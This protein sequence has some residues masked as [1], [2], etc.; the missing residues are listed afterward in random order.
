MTIYKNSGLVLSMQSAIAA[1]KTITLATNAAPGVFTSVGHGYLDGDIILVR[2]SG[3]IEVNER[4]FVV[5]NKAIDTF[6]LKNTATGAVGIDTT[7]FGVFSS[8]SAEKVTLA[9]SIPGVQEFSPSG[10]EIEFLDTTTVSDTRKKQMV[11]GISAM[12]YG[13][14]MMWDPSDTAQAAMQAAFETSST[15]SF[16]IKW[17]DGRYAMFF[18]SVGF[19]GA[20]GGGNQGITTTQAAISMNGNATYGIP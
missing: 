2:T 5:A 7:L 16:R 17:P 8:G 20:P 19:S 1:A 4:V 13:L 6:Q 10:G 14:T 9:T 11:S 18:G 15:K 3:M 12:S